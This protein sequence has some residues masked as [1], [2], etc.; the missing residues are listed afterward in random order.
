MRI[1]IYK[2]NEFIDLNEIYLK[3]RFKDELTERIITFSKTNIDF[4]SIGLLKGEK[5]ILQLAFQS[6]LNDSLN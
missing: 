4:S 3:G 6:I 1:E 5:N 2:D